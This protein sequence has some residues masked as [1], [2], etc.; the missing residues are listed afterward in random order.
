M[1]TDFGQ[2]LV[3]SSLVP[4][5]LFVPTPIV[6]YNQHRLMTQLRHHKLDDS[7]SLPGRFLPRE[8]PHVFVRLTCF[9]N[10]IGSS[11]DPVS[12]INRRTSSLRIHGHPPFIII[13]RPIRQPNDPQ[14]NPPI[15]PPPYK[16]NSK[17]TN[18][19]SGPPHGFALPEMPS[20]QA[21]RDA[22]MRSSTYLLQIIF[23]SCN[24]S[25]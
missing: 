9:V 23:V 15:T 19:N 1:M 17:T 4:F 8:H 12:V 10:G 21:C 22:Q 5:G 14:V 16:A 18:S 7:P 24:F 13:R 3:A 20:V 25:F 6:L 2:N 11:S